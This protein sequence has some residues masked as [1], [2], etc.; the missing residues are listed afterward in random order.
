VREGE[1]LVERLV[2]GEGGV[3]VLRLTSQKEIEG[4]LTVFEDI[5]HEQNW[6]TGDQLRVYRSRAVHFAIETEEKLT[7]GLQLVLGDVDGSLPCA[8]VWPELRIDGTNSAE[9]ALLALR[10]EHRGANRLF[11]PLCVE[12]WRYCCQRAISELWAEATPQNLRVYHRFG[13]PFAVMGPL[14]SH[15]GEDCY[16]CRISI[17]EAEA[18]FRQAAQKSPW[19]QELLGQAYRDDMLPTPVETLPPRGSA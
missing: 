12:V 15:W 10:R 3:S 19:R 14:R 9:I 1:V 16:P 4:L 17:V 18:A 5:A 11:W 8:A 6:R 7:G 2:C 13:W